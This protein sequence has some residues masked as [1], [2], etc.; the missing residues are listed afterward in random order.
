MNRESDVICLSH[1]RWGFVYQ[2]PNHLMARAAR[3]RRVFFFEVPVIGRGPSRLEVNQVASGLHVCTPHLPE[4]ISD[5][6]S[7]SIQRSLLAEMA[8]GR[9]VERP[10]VWSYTPMALPL[11]DVIEPALVVYDCMDELSAF[12][13]AHPELV[14]RERRLFSKADL[15][16]TGGQS[17]YEAKRA[18]H[19]AVHAFPSSVDAVH[20][21]RARVAQ[22]EPADQRDIPRPR[23]GYFGVID[24]RLDL[25]LLA[26]LA[27]ARP[28]YQFVMIGP[29]VKIEESSLPRRPNIHYLGGKKYDEL[30]EY[31]GGW[32]VA[33]MPFALNEATRFIS[34]TKT[35]E[36]LAAG[37]PV[38]S[39]AIRDV[40]RP[41]GEAQVVRIA[42]AAGFP[43]AIDAA[44]RTDR[45]AHHA[46]C[47]AVVAQTSWDKTW[48]SMSRLIED[49]IRD[50]SHQHPSR[51]AS[52]HNA[53][54]HNA[55]PVNP[56]ASMEGDDRC[57]T[58]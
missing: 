22:S 43:A 4:G 7:E 40:V 25:D 13:G 1:L 21:V 39:T 9:G 54:S 14:A 24:E 34:P 58:T 10:I 3:E 45:R 17:I 8:S 28:N 31:L 55:S 51:V 53:S 18:H 29:A 20:F 33:M 52:S 27:D 35:L 16:F 12:R 19:C 15:V 2:R 11:T 23:V 42:D 48:R 46:T 32:D 5:H 37:R 41:Y 36:Y 57:S 38:V 49:A 56:S 47:D 26:S 50:R 30:P 6:E 44:L